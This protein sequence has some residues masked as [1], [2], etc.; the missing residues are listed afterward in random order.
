MDEILN[1]F[2]NVKYKIKN[3][4]NAMIEKGI[5][6]DFEDELYD[7][8]IAIEYINEMIKNHTKDKRRGPV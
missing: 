5:S 1:S 4:E 6:E 7:V 2:H 3:L 8:N